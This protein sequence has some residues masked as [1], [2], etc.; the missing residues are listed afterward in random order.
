MARPSRHLD[1]ALL[2]SGAELYPQLGFAGLSV[3]AV[4]ARAGT[5]AGTFHYYF[6]SKEVF[7]SELLQRF[8]DDMFVRLQAPAEA[9]GDPLLRLRHALLTLAG[10]VRDQAP[11][12]RRALADAEAGHAVAAN[13]LRRNLPRHLGL[14]RRLLA[15]AERAGLIPARPPLLRLTFLL[16]AV[17]AP[18]LVASALREHELLPAAARGQVAPQVL[19]DEAI[20]QRADLALR[21]LTMGEPHDT[22]A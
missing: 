15:E 18:V 8:Y 19:S 17:V 10:V 2:A 22:E 9:A 3:R 6:E 4:A 21:A 11:L 12:V 5:S 7:L 20:A 14:L 16:G 1:R 13:F